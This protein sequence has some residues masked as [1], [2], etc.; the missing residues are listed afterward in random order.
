MHTMHACTQCIQT[1]DIERAWQGLA[2]C[3][4]AVLGSCKTGT[5]DHTLAS[6]LTMLALCASCALLLCAYYTL[7]LSASCALA[8]CA[9]CTSSIMRFDRMCIMRFGTFVHHAL[10]R[11]VY[12][13]L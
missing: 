7:A 9:Y 1:E 3:Q 13:V 6:K 5:T 8:L 10:W 12:P 4:Q 11:F 2:S